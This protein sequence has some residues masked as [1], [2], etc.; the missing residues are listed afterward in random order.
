MKERVIVIGGGLAGSEA[1]W[2]LANEGHK[3]ILYEMRPKKMTPAHKTGNLAELVCSNT[4]GGLELTTGAGLLKAEMKMLGSLVIEA[5]SVSRV[6]AGGALG[7][8][9]KIFSEYITEKIENHPNITVIREEIKEIP[10]DDIVIIATGPLTSEALSEKIKELVG[11]DT[12]YFYDAIAPIVDAESVDFNKGFWGSR[13]GKGGDD[14]FNCVLS[15]EEYKVFYE[16]LLKA[17]KVKPKDFE[18]A[19]HFEGCLPIEEMAQRGYKTL[20]YGPMRPVGLIDPRTGKEPF[21]VVQLRKENK[22]GTLLSLVGFQTKLTY[23]EQ[24]RVFKLIPCLKNA[25]FVRLGSMHRNTFIQSNKV[26]T[27]CLNLRK[28]ENIFFAG[29]ITGVEGYVASSATGILAGINAGRLARGE[30]LIQAPEETMLGALVK[31]ITT[32]EGELQPMNPV[33]GLLPPLKKKIKDKRKRK[34]FMA[35]RALKSMENWIKDN[36][37][38]P[39]QLVKVC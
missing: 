20:L 13:Y 30:K 33:F 25:V 26:L 12:L 1:A 22:E 18:K 35:K 4:L 3:V 5:A 6:P 15:E 34:E 38:V 16:E 27:P 7:V 29:Q 19:V 9:R 11:Y 17:E 14:Y 31:Y 23:K 8:D 21:A 10:E 28:K 2:R 39:S 32:K 24:K 36:N 37:L